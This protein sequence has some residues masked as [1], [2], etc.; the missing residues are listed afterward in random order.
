MRLCKTLLLLPLLSSPVLAQDDKKADVQPASC[1]ELMTELAVFESTAETIVEDTATG[2][3]ATD[4]LVVPGSP[5]RFKI[6]ELTLV[7][8][9]LLDDYAARRLPAEVDLTLSGVLLSPETGSELATYMIEMQ[10]EPMTIHLA[11]R[12]DRDARTVDLADLSVAAP[13]FGSFSLAGQFS[14]AQLDA[15]G[16]DDVPRM[17]GAIDHLIV[18]IKNARFAAT[19]FAPPLIGML[20][21]DQDPRPLVASY[22]AA[23]NAFIA[24]LPPA[25]VSDESKTALTTFVSDF[26][27]PRGDYTIELAADP[28]IPF[29]SFALDDP[30]GLVALLS[31]LKIAASHTPPAV[32]PTP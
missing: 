21:F 10:A 1:A 20:P 25:N 26:P 17:P 12:W 5:S 8:P 19:Y 27:R 32:A 16:L 3:H 14:D 29:A 31:R 2:C 13:E 4:L 28:G 11:Y 30:A 22:I 23:V 7:A 24:N 15:N 6:A 18:D 9:G